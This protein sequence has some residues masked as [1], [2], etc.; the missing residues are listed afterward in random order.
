MLDVADF[1]SVT[2]THP[3]PTPNTSGGEP[4]CRF[5]R[6]IP[7]APKPQPADRSADGTLPVDAFRYCEPVT[8]AS[9][10]G[11]HFFPP[12]S[13]RLMWSGDEVIYTFGGRSRWRS[14]R[15]VHFPH[16][17]KAFRTFAPAYLADYAPPLL[18]QTSVPGT[19][20]I[21]TGYFA[22]TAPG[23]ALMSRGVVNRPRKE[24]Y[25]NLE[26]IVETDDWF[27][28]LFT[29]VRLL[30]TNSPVHFPQGAPFLQALPVPRPAYR[31]PP[32]AVYEAT[33]MTDS[34]W[35]A[36]EPIAKRANNHLRD[37]GGYAVE[38][39]R[40]LRAEEAAAS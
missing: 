31:K 21:W 19:V 29:N 4:I 18:V 26:A 9:G 33:E 13:F 27:G 32:F 6:L 30:R 24:P 8:S 37:K 20:Q 28:P 10:F 17:P 35:R 39:R 5:Y 15:G 36:Y 14:L 34:D 22:R 3:A 12:I 25:E 40:R 1:P 38:T 16:F 2:E 11:W 23:W 7:D